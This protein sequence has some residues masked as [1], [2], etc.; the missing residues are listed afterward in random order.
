MRSRSTFWLY[1]G[2]GTTTMLA[3]VAVAAM[4]AAP[5]RGAGSGWYTDAQARQG[6][7][8]FDNLCAQCHRPD[9]TGA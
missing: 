8:L 6:H 7:Q 9:L 4:S 5:M 3:S 2:I 1:L